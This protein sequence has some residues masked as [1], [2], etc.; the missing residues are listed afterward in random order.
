VVE[1]GWFV[2]LPSLSRDPS[3]GI[4]PHARFA[5][6]Y[7]LFVQRGFRK[8]KPIHE[9]LFIQQQCVWLRCDGNVYSRGDGVC[10]IFMGLAHVDEEAGRGGGLEDCEDLESHTH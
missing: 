3:G 4:T 7:N 2:D 5:K 1:V 9:L 10:F 6:E 8:S